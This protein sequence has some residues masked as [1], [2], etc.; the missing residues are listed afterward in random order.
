MEDHSSRFGDQGRS[1][2]QNFELMRAKMKCSNCGAEISNLNMSWGWKHIL[3]MAP[4]LLLGFFPIL[5]MT[6]FS[7]DIAAELSISDTQMRSQEGRIEIVGLITNSGSRTW[8]GVTIEAEF[9]DA[10]GEF[11]DEATEYL[12][13]DLMGNAEE[14]FKVTITN[15]GPGLD[16]PDTKMVV[17][18][19]GGRTSPF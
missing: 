18:V 13:T 3:I 17:K 5:K 4:I 2:Q 8:T 7:G 19:A 12:T 9:F 15:P 11:I 6:F 14:H 1:P 16:A 10:A